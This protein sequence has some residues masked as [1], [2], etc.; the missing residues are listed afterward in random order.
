MRQ[1]KQA[2]ALLLLVVMLALH[3]CGSANPLARA[4]TVEQK[5]YAAYGTFV[6]IEEQAAKAV[7]SGELSRSAVVRI[8]DADRRAKPVADSL[9][10]ATLEFELIRDEYE[11]SGMGEERLIAA[12]NSLNDWV[13]RLTPLI[14]NLAASVK[15]EQ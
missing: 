8:G 11:E 3:A 9:L 14:N 6:I 15:G 5:A 4:E 2:Q 7:S 1:V 13:T 10:E 12:I